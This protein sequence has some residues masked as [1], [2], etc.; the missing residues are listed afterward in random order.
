MFCVGQNKV[1][2]FFERN[3]LCYHFQIN[4]IAVN[5]NIEWQIKHTFDDKAEEY[6]INF[7]TMPMLT[8]ASQLPTGPY[9]VAELPDN[10]TLL[11]KQ[12]KKFPLHF[13][14]EVFCSENL[15][16]CEEKIDW[17]QCLLTKDT[18]VL[19]VKEI[20]DSFKPFDVTI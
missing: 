2:T 19:I 11:T 5:I 18:E 7:D 4:V 15:L 9:F 8:D 17:R 6:N 12:M 14:R 16:H 10:T 13:G 20:R 1:V 3:Y